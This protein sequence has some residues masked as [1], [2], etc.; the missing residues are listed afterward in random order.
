MAN[1]GLIGFT[2]DFAKMLRAAGVTLEFA[3]GMNKGLNSKWGTFTDKNIDQNSPY[4]KLYKAGIK[5]GYTLLSP[6]TA[7]AIQ[8]KKRGTVSPDVQKLFDSITKLQTEEAT[9]GGPDTHPHKGWFHKTLDIISRP[10][11]A[12][13]TGIFRD[14]QAIKDAKTAGKPAPGFF[15][16]GEFAK[17]AKAGFLGRDS[18]GGTDILRQ[19]GVKNRAALFAG[20][21]GIDVA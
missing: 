6:E 5:P 12:V 10:G 7:Q 21:F 11:R 14:E 1:S 20:G 9:R 13:T 15:R 18:K 4:M 3:G 8:S 2:P 16:F 19:A 17:G